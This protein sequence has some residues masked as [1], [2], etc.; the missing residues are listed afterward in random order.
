[1]WLAQLPAHSAYPLHV[2]APTLAVAAG[3][4]VTMMP[5][6]VAATTG[7]APRNAGVASGLINMCRQLG[8]ALGLAVLVTVASVITSHSQ[9]HGPAAVVQGYHTALL[10]VAAASVATALIS[11][12]LKRT[13]APR[14]E[15]T[16][17]A[18]S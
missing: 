10:A 14:P 5:T 13:E 15:Q 11:L 4:S 7:V 1:V 8:A 6:I 9:A 3:T 18:K 16:D 17:A 12:F 2:L